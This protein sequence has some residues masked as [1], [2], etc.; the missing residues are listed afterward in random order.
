MLRAFS[1]L[2]DIPAARRGWTAAAASNPCSKAYLVSEHK[3]ERTLACSRRRSPKG[4]KEC[5][6]DSPAKDRSADSASSHWTCRH[7]VAKL[8]A[9]LALVLG[10]PPPSSPPSSSK[11]TAEGG[12]LGPRLV[13]VVV[14]VSQLHGH[15]D[16]PDAA[17]L[18]A[19]GGQRRVTSML[20]R[21]RGTSV[22]RRQCA[23]MP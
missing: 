22:Q 2:H 1:H 23:S 4:C 17:H 20:R 12:G 16:A 5:G 10:L 14:G 8:P 11:P 21:A 3:A 18:L 13:E 19:A 6:C 15:D 7:C 9:Q